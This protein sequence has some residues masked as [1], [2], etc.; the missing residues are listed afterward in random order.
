MDDNRREETEILKCLHLIDAKFI[1]VTQ[2]LAD[3]I[4]LREEEAD[5]KF[6]AALD[7]M[8]ADI[9]MLRD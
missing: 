6:Y 4:V 8:F 1:T 3:Y 5:L 2:K 9:L 7:A